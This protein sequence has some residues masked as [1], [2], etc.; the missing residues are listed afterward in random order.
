MAS[1]ISQFLEK[2][3]HWEKKNEL[4]QETAKSL[5]E[6]DKELEIASSE[7]GVNNPE[8]VKDSEAT[9]KIVKTVDI[10]Q[11][12]INAGRQAAV[13]Q[14]Q[15][16]EMER[17]A[18]VSQAI[19]LMPNSNVNPNWDKSQEEGRVQIITHPNMSMINPIPYAEQIGQ[20]LDE[21]SDEKLH[22]II[23]N[24]NTA[25]DMA[26]DIQK[27]NEEKALLVERLAE[28]TSIYRYCLD[29][30]KGLT[31]KLSKIAEEYV[32]ENMKPVY[33]TF[34]NIMQDKD[35][36]EIATWPTNNQTDPVFTLFRNKET[37]QYL[38]IEQDT[39]GYIINANIGT[40]GMFRPDAMPHIERQFEAFN[41]ITGMWSQEQLDNLKDNMVANMM[42]HLVP[43]HYNAT[44]DYATALQQSVEMAN[45]QQEKM[46]ELLE[47]MIEN[48]GG[49][50][51]YYLQ[52][53]EGLHMS[54]APVYNYILENAVKI[55]QELAQMNPPVVIMDIDLR[56]DNRMENAT[57][58]LANPTNHLY[59]RT[60]EGITV[61]IDLDARQHQPTLVA[62]D[63]IPS[64]T[65]E[66]TE[67]LDAIGVPN[68]PMT[69]RVKASEV[70]SS[71]V[72]EN[73]LMDYIKDSVTQC[74]AERE[75]TIENDKNLVNEEND[76]TK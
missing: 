19:G 63:Y 62:A 40:A 12:I 6:A 4:L 21:V 30:T 76:I 31:D 22:Q 27:S 38:Q 46:R 23:E 67:T 49:R 74:R 35:N 42:Q 20:S 1:K 47:T 48:K 25:R 43:E 52:E 75:Q 72:F 14:E 28:A 65:L 36:W 56:Q 50:A 57:G 29:E 55:A 39:Q 53:A 66:E 11:N 9:H 8:R 71:Y 13:L 34:A 41:T 73:N 24:S 2:L 45:T 58:G 54:N 68:D 59:L 44:K 61:K 16:A 70:S 15:Q 7:L 51:L 17:Q 18:T 60:N 37:N 26:I 10:A 5:N 33:L 3:S 64:K 32:I 69:E